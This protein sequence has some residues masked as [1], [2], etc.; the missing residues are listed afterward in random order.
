MK[1]S[2]NLSVYSKADI[3]VEPSERRVFKP[4]LRIAT[5]P[6]AKRNSQYFVGP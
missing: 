6:I 4:K 5:H 1:T 3:Q 2:L